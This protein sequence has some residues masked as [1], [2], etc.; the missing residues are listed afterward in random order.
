MVVASNGPHL[1]L[2]AYPNVLRRSNLV[3]RLRERVDR[4][5]TS[6]S[7]YGDA[8]HPLSTVFTGLIE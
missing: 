2:A 8:V 5:R 1:G 3:E 4:P 7:L 6:V